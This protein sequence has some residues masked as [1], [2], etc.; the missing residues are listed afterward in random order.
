MPDGHRR[1]RSQVTAVDELFGTHRL[2][3]VIAYFFDRTR[4]LGPM[5]SESGGLHRPFTCFMDT[6][7]SVDKSINSPQV[8]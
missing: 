8:E 7:P 1:A 2:W 4:F 6:R 5:L 3:G